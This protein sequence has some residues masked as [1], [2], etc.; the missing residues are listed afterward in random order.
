MPRPLRDFVPGGFYHVTARGNGGRPIVRDDG[1]REDF[2]RVLARTAPRF[3]IH[4]HAWCLM[5]NHYH[6][7]IEAPSG[8]VSKAIQYL[9]GI[10]ARRFNERHERSG[11]LFR[12]RFR[13]TVLD[14]EEH[15]S[16]ACRYVLLNPVR[17]GLVPDAEAWRWAGGAADA[18][19]P[20]P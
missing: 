11:H 2:V 9:N 17:A 5:T 10:Y 4:V 6:L 14:C 15:L 7:I 13:A 12:A 20:Q 3:G 16:A 8:E 19:G 1:D 18:V